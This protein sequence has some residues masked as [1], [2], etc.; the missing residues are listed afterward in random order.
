MILSLLLFECQMNVIFFLLQK[1]IWNYFLTSFSRKLLKRILL[2]TLSEDCALCACVIGR[3]TY[4][5]ENT[6][7]PQL[8]YWRL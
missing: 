8:C 1:L 2:S 4:F 7:L 3:N 5:E 6:S